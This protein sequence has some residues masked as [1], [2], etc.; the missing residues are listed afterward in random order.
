MVAFVRPWTDAHR[1]SKYEALCDYLLAVDLPM[2]TVSLAEVEKRGEGWYFGHGGSNWGYRCSLIAH[3]RKGYGVV[4][5][6][7][8]DAG[9]GVIAEI[10][11]RVAAA[12]GWDSLDKPLLR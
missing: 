12:Y 7:N 3:V 8:G 10:E 6:T 2:V 1:V 9:G 5:M 11:A 4:V